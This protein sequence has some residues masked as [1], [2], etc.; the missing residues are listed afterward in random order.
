MLTEEQRSKRKDYDKQYKEKN[1][2]KINAYSLEHRA[3]VKEYRLNHL[4][5]C[6]KKDREYA[7]KRRLDP[8]KKQRINEQARKYRRTHPKHFSEYNAKINRARRIEVLNHY[9]SPPV[10]FCCGE[11]HIEFLTIDHVNGDGAK[12]RKK[13]KGHNIYKWL[14]VHNYPE[15]FRVLCINC[16]WSIGVWGYCP[17]QV[18]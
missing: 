5:E 12:H 2:D 3:K 16:N 14:K 7:V 8:I 4:E 6:R 10:C 18:K 17:H 13:D 15:G 1:K 9:S 11:A